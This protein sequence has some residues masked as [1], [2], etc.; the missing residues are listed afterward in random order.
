M[1]PAE[2]TKTSKIARKGGS[3][4]QPQVKEPKGHREDM[5]TQFKDEN[6]S[7]VLVNFQGGFKA[8]IG[9]PVKFRQILLNFQRELKAN[10]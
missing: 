5:K 6:S 7:N 3:G 1:R 9:I 4:H 8:N 2:T 10:N